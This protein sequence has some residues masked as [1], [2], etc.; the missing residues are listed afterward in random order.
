MGRHSATSS[1]SFFQRHKV[2]TGVVGAFVV[3]GVI[4][5]IAG[6]PAEQEPAG[7]VEA[8]TLPAMAEADQ[9]QPSDKTLLS[10]VVN[11]ARGIG[12]AEFTPESY[13]AVMSLISEGGAVTN[14]LDD[15]NATQAQVD[16]AVT[17]LTDA[18]SALQEINPAPAASLSQ[19]NALN[20]ANRYLSLMHFSRSG[21][22]S[23][24]EYE[25]YPTEDATYA[26]DSCGADWYA[27]AL[28]KGQDYLSM[29]A[30]SYSGLI[31]QL[32]YEGFSY[33]EAAYAAN[34][35]GADWNDQAAR[36]A[37]DYLALMSFSRDGLIDQLQYEGFSYDE[38]SYGA[39]AVGY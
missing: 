20:Q 32:Q 31:E 35:C 2:A 34:N 22:I 14:V 5:S 15:E 24:L 26:A 19:S 23:Q 17:M 25:G 13:E 28:G 10:G 3:L 33:D 8:A 38:A 4:G 11:N 16:S 37:S 29:S 30:F 27:Q 6:Q 18:I 12:G 1:G 9:P 21:L 39:S 36:K 7:N